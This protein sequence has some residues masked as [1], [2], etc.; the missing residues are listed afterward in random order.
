MTAAARR[1]P[2]NVRDDIV[3]AAWGLFRQLGVHTTIADVAERL[4][5]SSAN[6]YRF[7]PSKQAL[8]D[9]VCASQLAALTDVARAAATRPGSARERARAMI[10]AL[11]AAMREQMLHEARVH[12]IVNVALNERWPAI[13]AFMADC[14][15][16]L[17]AVIAEGQARSEF[18]AGDAR[19][20]ALHT[21]FACVAVFHPALIA[22]RTDLD[23]S[24]EDAVDF[25]LRA[26]ANRDSGARSA[27]PGGEFAP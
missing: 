10:L 15:E 3:T 1:S 20:L 5:M 2:A 13:D 6:I 16:M 8:T 23:P 9:A 18:A 21:L 27:A 19:T 12:E 24:P 25:V 4:G 11:H 7:F 14:A 26:L 17:A 22:Q